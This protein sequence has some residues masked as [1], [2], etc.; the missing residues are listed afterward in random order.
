MYFVHINYEIHIFQISQSKTGLIS[1]LNKCRIM[2][3]LKYSDMGT[4]FYMFEQKNKK[5]NEN[6]QNVMYKIHGKL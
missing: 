1:T 4:C 6:L 5:Q 3:A 2:F